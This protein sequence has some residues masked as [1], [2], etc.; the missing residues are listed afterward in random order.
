MS[1]D[2]NGAE[3][4]LRLPGSM[5]NW[6][7]LDRGPAGSSAAAR[8]IVR[9]FVAGAH[10]VAIVGPHCADLI[11]GIAD[12]VPRL[13]VIVRSVADSATIGDLLQD[14]PGARVVATDLTLAAPQETYDL[15]IALDDVDRVCSLE[16][17]PN[18][19]QQMF[20]LITGLVAEGGRLVFV[21]ENELGLHRMTA[22]RSRFTSNED[23]DWSPT[24]TF[25]RSR[26]RDPGALTAAV[27]AA[28]L[29]ALRGGVVLPTWEDQSVWVAGG[30]ELDDGGHA[31]LGALTLGSPTFRQVGSDPTRLTRAA[32]LAR[33]LP[34]VGSGWWV[35][36][37][38]GV[39]GE[40]QVTRIAASASDGS[41][42]EF[43]FDGGRVLRGDESVT[44][45]ADGRAF[46]E[47]LLDAAADGDLSVMRSMVRTLVGYVDEH[48]SDGS[49][50]AE[51]A[52]A[53]PDNLLLSKSGLYSVTRAAAAAPRDEV[54]WR[55]LADFVQ[56]IRARGARH[57]WP[58]ATDDRTMFA[59]LAAMA[60]VELPEDV[61]DWVLPAEG[62]GRAPVADVSGLIAVVERLTETNKALA[63]RATWY[64]QRLASTERDLK[65]RTE[66][67]RAQL[68]TAARQQEVLRGSAEDLRRSLTYRLGNAV[69]G[70]VRNLRNSTRGD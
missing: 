45:P 49:V 3:K 15:V 63:S 61:N 9:E 4:V 23:S 67:H 48:A 53:R 17:D 31:I 37:G 29:T 52:D 58:S 62:E 44:V 50:A 47:E 66:R 42:I 12:V 38:R 16:T 14:T 43:C 55:A 59:S 65:M 41:T 69:L 25:D 30:D 1:G 40:P 39:A 21:T 24:E 18:T 70:P 20:D 60:G 10:N 46:G 32:V 56:V 64:E 27:R 57:P 13:T 5:Q 33:R 51:H 6:S 34:Q 36:A 35:V 22:V 26:P 7:D 11:T 2:E 68:A 28:G 8:S 19:W 54:I